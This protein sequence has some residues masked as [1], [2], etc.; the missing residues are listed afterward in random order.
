LNRLRQLRRAKNAAQG[1]IANALLTKP[2]K[3]MGVRFGDVR[4]AMFFKKKDKKSDAA[5]DGA[6][7]EAQV[8]ATTDGEEGAPA[9]A[10]KGLPLKM[11]IVVGA[12][13]LLLLGGGGAGLYFFVLKSKPDAANAAHPPKKPKKPKGHGEPG[14]PGEKDEAGGLTREGPDGVTYYTMPDL[15]VNIQ[16][17]DGKPTFLKLTLTFEMKDEEVAEM[18]PAEAPRLKDMFQ[19]FLRELRPEDLNGS[20][21]SF[22]LRQEI[23]RRANL[24]LAPHK[25]DAV[26]IEEMLIQ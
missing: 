13:G 3:S 11:L 10:R 21:G 9:P 2:A 22:Q 5:A 25:I 19:T 16:T 12:A 23:Q 14:K 1:P 17:A 15:V 4:A 7:G 26:L 8:P 20:Q 6:E 18:M 24:V